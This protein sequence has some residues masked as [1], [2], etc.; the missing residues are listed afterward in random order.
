LLQQDSIA[1]HT[2][3]AEGSDSVVVQHRPLTP[4]QVLSCLPR[5][6]TPAQQD[7]AIQAHFKPSEI[8]WSEHPDTLHLP[9]HSPGVD[10]MKADL[11][12]YYKESF[13]S[14]SALFHPELPGGRYGVPG[15]P[16]PYTVRNDNLI[17]SLLLICFIVAVIAFGNVRQFIRRQV[18]FFFS[19]PTESVVEESETVNELYFQLLLVFITSLLI[20]LL[21]YFYTLNFI[22]NTFVLRSQYTL[23]SIYLGI[24]I[25][26]FLLKMGYYAMVN[27][28]FFGSKKN[29]Q[30]IK[31]WLFIVSVEGVLF[32]PAVLLGGY[33]EMDVNWMAFYVILSCIIVKLLTI[34]KVYMIFFRRNV[35]RL[36]IFLYFCTLEIVPLLTFWGALVLTA[37]SLKINF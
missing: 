36:Q 12:Q 1:N 32:F 20:A 37:N 28:V 21:F 11:P 24:T 14:K 29:K 3:V 7:S 25:A 23:I 17:T 22:G 13:F 15:D 18:K 8:H 4:A 2:A 27:L 19:A 5:D 16:I 31:T 6:A 33:F 35:V 9:G 34:Y 26:Y 10:L 30:W